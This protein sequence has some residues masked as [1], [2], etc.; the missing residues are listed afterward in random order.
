MDHTLNNGSH[1]KKWVTL[2]KWVVNEKMG[3]TWK[4]D[5]HVEKNGSQV[6][7]TDHAWKNNSHLKKGHT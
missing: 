1:L 7:K 4:N 5:L 6:R 3:Q 2:E